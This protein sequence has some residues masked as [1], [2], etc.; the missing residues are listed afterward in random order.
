MNII[1]HWLSANYIELIAAILGLLG[2]WL[3]A[4]QYIWCW[5]V[6]LVNVLLSGYVFFTA[7]L[8]ADVV[9]QVFYLVMTIYGWYYWVFGG[10][11][12]YELPVRRIRKKELIFM[13][14]IGMVGSATVGFI[15]YKFTN[16][17]YPFWDSLLMVWGIIGTYAMAKKILEHWIMWIIIDLNCTALYFFKGL[18][19]FTPQYFIFTLLAVYGYYE[20]IKDYK[21]SQAR[22]NDI[23]G[24]DC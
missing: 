3:T 16:A 14:I 23:A 21:K 13:L 1:L 12:K 9:L 11:K 2:V 22:L 7:R 18:Y 4:K 15:F 5:P 24:Q 6:G 17:A 20:W 19:A 10:K 8:Y